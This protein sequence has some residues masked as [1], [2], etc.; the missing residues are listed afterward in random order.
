LQTNVGG[1]IIKLQINVGV[2]ANQCRGKHPK[3]Y[4]KMGLSR[5]RKQ[6]LKQEI[7]KTRGKTS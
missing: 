7:Y 1:N 5:L 6:D 3:Y 2:I 4:G